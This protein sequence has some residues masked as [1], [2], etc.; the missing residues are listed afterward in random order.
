M[1]ALYR[2]GPM[3]FIPDYIERKH[4]PH[5]VKYPDERFKKIL[6][7]TFGILIYQDDIMTIAV[8]FAGYSW[9]EADKF[10]KAMGKKIPEVMAQQKEKFCTGCK[11][12]G[13]NARQ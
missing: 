4:N 8:D 10:R 12:V 11:E 6:E 7:P 13:E 1:V 5:K 2:P 9:G 3:A